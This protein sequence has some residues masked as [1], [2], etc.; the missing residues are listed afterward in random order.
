MVFEDA[1]RRHVL[2]TM[3]F[4]VELGARAEIGL[5]HARPLI[6]RQN[7]ARSV[8][9]LEV[10][11]HLRERRGAVSRPSSGSTSAWNFDVSLRHCSS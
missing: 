6:A 11:A 8:D 5:A 1:A 10:A 3:A 4:R 2:E 9:V 7:G